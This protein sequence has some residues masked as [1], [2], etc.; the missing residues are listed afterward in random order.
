MQLRFD[1]VKISVKQTGCR[2]LYIASR[3]NDGSAFCVTPR[4]AL[5]QFEHGSLCL[6]LV[7]CSQGF[8]G[9]RT[10]IARVIVTLWREKRHCSLSSPTAAFA[11]RSE[12]ARQSSGHIIIRLSGFPSS[13]ANQL[14]NRHQH[15][16]KK[17]H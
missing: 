6:H 12:K 10:C 8:T 2:Y 5:E 13:A 1:E 4:V 9:W 7:K 3:G 15:S 17:R 11:G 14:L 16:L